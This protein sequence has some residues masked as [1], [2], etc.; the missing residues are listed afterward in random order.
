MK[1]NWLTVLFWTLIIGGI[2]VKITYRFYNFGMP[3]LGVILTGIGI[4]CLN[5]FHEKK[6]ENIDNENT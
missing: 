1:I 6:Q 5:L 3:Y 4:I 2:L